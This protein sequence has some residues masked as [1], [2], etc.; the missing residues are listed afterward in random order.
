[1][2]INYPAK[3]E[4]IDELINKLN[5][6]TEVL[7]NIFD[8][9]GVILQKPAIVDDTDTSTSGSGN[10]PEDDTAPIS[11]FKASLEVDVKP[12]IGGDNEKIG[13]L[14]GVRLTFD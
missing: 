13:V 11:P 14:V 6:E 2:E 7:E 9:E 5:E 12:N 4:N 3:Q 8:G 10:Q 1:M